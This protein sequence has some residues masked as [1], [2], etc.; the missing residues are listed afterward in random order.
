MFKVATRG[1]LW[2]GASPVDD[3]AIA[4]VP[5]TVASF[6]ALDE[7]GPFLAACQGQYR[8]VFATALFTGM[9]EGE[10]F[11]LRKQDVNWKTNEITVRPSAGAGTPRPQSRA[12]TWSSRS[13]RT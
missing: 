2:V 11:G 5:K 8:Q 4:E 3:V 13:R 9:R 6:L 1:G 10:L 12:A 7:V